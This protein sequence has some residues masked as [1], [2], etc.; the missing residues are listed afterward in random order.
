[1]FEFLSRVPV[2]PQPAPTSVSVP[3]GLDFLSGINW[4]VVGACAVVAAILITMYK[5]LPK[6]VVVILIVLGAITV[7]V[8]TLNSHAVGK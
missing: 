1:M 3:T 6:W 2:A 7:G 8:F 5:N 4:G